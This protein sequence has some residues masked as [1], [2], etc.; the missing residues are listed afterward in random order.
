VFRRTLF[1]D[2]R[3]CLTV[4]LSSFL[5]FILVLLMVVDLVPFFIITQPFSNN[6]GVCV[7]V[8]RYLEVRQ[9]RRRDVYCL[10]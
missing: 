3:F 6:N 8:C 5:F 1:A 7:K 9:D 4:T 2:D 10:A